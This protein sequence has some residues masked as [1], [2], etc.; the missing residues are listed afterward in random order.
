M[1]HRVTV[2]TR[3]CLAIRALLLAAAGTVAAPAHAGQSCDELKAQIEAKLQAKHVSNYSL[4]IL[5][6]GV[7][8]GQARTVGTCDAGARKIVYS[9]K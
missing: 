5:D 2:T 6:N 3:R 4:E 9:R 8:P 7:D 1:P